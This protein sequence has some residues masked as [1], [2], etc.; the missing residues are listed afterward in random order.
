MNIS[1]VHEPCKILKFFDLPDEVK[2][3]VFQYLSPQ[4]LTGASLVCKEWNRLGNDNLLWKQLALKN[5]PFINYSIENF[6]QEFKNFKILNYV[7]HQDYDIQVDYDYFIESELKNIKH[8]G[9]PIDIFFDSMGNLLYNAK[10]SIL[11]KNAKIDLHFWDKK[12]YEKIGLF[13]NFR[14]QFNDD[15]EFFKIR[16]KKFVTYLNQQLEKEIELVAENNLQKLSRFT[17]RMLDIDIQLFFDKTGNIYFLK[18]ADE[19][20]KKELIRVQISKGSIFTSADSVTYQGIE[21]R[22][23]SFPLPETKQDAMSRVIALR[24]IQKLEKKCLL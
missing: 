8:A 18:Y 11:A 15:G 9:K 21:S 2:Q 17:L 13:F 20:I 10:A 6:K 16:A 5:F 7:L 23:S 22:F 14:L 3:Y 1:P 19:R 24:T 12:N 4:E